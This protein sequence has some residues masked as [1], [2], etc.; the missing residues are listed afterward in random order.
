M[1]WLLATVLVLVAA[2]CGGAGSLGHD[3]NRAKGEIQ[4]AKQFQSFPL[5]W[6]GEQFESW[7][8]SDILLPPNEGE[9]ATIVYGD[10]TPTGGDE[11]SC[12][13]PI[14]LQ[15]MPLC[16]HLR[17]VA[18]TPSWRRRQV[19]GAPVGTNLDGAPV[20][21]SA[22]VQVKVYRGEGTR[23][24]LEL[25]VLRA[26]RSLNSVPPLLAPSGP[27]PAPSRKVLAGSEACRVGR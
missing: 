6:A 12:D 9:F 20:L 19:R 13:P 14:A 15:I 4:A 22:R 26:L 24:G 23:P 8:V 16:R 11:P 18:G 21:F 5:Y 10:C 7:P 25:R 1:R 27:I 2:G 3:S 17:V